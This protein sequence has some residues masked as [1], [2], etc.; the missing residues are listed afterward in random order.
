MNSFDKYVRLIGP[1]GSVF[2]RRLL[3][4]VYNL[5]SGRY[6]LSEKLLNVKPKRTHYLPAAKTARKLDLVGWFFNHVVI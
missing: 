6:F 2:V 1:L 3:A 4:V 5:L